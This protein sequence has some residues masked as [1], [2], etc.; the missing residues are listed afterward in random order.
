MTIKHIDELRAKISHKEE[1]RD[2]EVSNA[3]MAVGSTD[4]FN[5]FCYMVA[6]ADTFDD[7]WSRECRG[8]VFRGTR[9]AGRP[10]HKFFN[11]NE[12]PETQ[13]NAL[14]WDKVVRVMEKRDGSMIHT[15]R[16][17]HEVANPNGGGNLR[18]F[19]LKSKKSFESDVVK[20]AWGKIG[21]V[22]DNSFYDFQCFCREIAKLDCTA[23]FEFTSPDARIVLHYPKHE[24]YLLAVRENESG[25]YWS[26]HEMVGLAD[27]YG[28][29]LVNEVDEFWYH[30][31]TQPSERKFLVSAMLEAAKTRENVEGWVI[32]FEDGEMVKVKTEWY[33]RRHKAMTFLR[34][35]DIAVMVVAQELDDLKALMVGDGVDIKELLEIEQRVLNDIRGIE[36]ALNAIAPAEDFK[37]ER[38]DFVMKHREKAGALFGLL[39]NK[40][41]GKE[42]NYIEHFEKHILKQQYTLRVINLVPTVA[43]AE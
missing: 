36:L 29:N 40:F 6:G 37:L 23:I 9:V 1:I 10:F 24:F 38:K 13:V 12:R 30:E 33:L 39:M 28:I 32:Q 34:E 2:A 22:S 14:P 5:V 35:R 15:V 3:N 25:R 42:P 7:A 18:G 17:G 20:L 19:M 21:S 43:E 41:S 31:M 4:R 26:T 27:R 16:C 8:I 11:M